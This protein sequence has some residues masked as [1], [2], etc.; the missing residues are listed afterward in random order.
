MQELRDPGVL[1][2]AHGSRGKPKTVRLQLTEG[3]IT[4]RTETR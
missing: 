2:V 4:W 1:V 3:A